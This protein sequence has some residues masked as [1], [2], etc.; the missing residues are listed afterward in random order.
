VGTSTARSDFYNG[1]TF[2]ARVYSERTGAAAGS[3]AH[4]AAIQNSNDGEPS[5]VLLGKSRGTSAGSAALVNSGDIIGTLT[6]QGA[7]GTN[8][9]Q[10]ASIN[11]AVDGTPA[12]NDMPGRIVLSTTPSG[13]ATPTE[14][15]RLTSTGALLVGTSTTPTGAAAGAVVAENRLIVGS[16]NYG[17]N[18]LY[19]GSPGTISGT[20]GTLVFKFKSLSPTSA[21]VGFIKVTALGRTT[22]TTPSNSPVAEYA[23]QLF[24]N[25]SGVCSL[26]NATTIFEYTFVRATHFAFA[27][28]GSGECTVTLTNPTGVSLTSVYKV[29]ITTPSGTWGLDT[30]TVT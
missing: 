7:D 17:L 2:G 11:C 16:A 22:N 13:S 15:V 30:V 20:V 3:Y 14:R 24:H 29:E 4:Y 10:A 28:L 23:F 26:N 27:D 19:A 1:T 9:V 18:Q 21:R 5:I 12:A 6:Y 25:S 8:L